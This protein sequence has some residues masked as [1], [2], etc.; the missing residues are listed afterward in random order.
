MPG[1]PLC[2]WRSVRVPQAVTLFALAI[3]LPLHMRTPVWCDHTL[4]DVAARNLLWGGVLYRDVFDTNLP[5]FVWLMTA[6]RW[7]FGYGTPA[8]RI[9][10]L[11][12]VASIVLFI[13][14]IARR[15]G[16]TPASRWW[17]IA[18]V[19]VLYPSAVE[20]AHAQR[21]TWMALPAVAALFLRLRRA[22]MLDVPARRAF[23]LAFLEG[24]LWEWR[25]GSNRTAFSWPRAC[26]S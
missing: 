18:A 22:A 24:A 5:G 2:P 25:C 3:G 16:A 17:A 1:F 12:V 9:V 23:L 6:I 8:F 7:A 14:R 21:D 11:A 19:A 26:G 15:G 20:M 10:D 4:Y 13:D